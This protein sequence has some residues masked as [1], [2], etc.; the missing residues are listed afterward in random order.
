MALRFGHIG[1]GDEDDDP[2]V[3]Q[4]AG[5]QFEQIMHGHDLVEGHEEDEQGDE[6]EAIE[7]AVD[8]RLGRENATQQG[9]VCGQTANHCVAKV[10]GEEVE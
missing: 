7:E 1:Q 6:G 9:P 3:V 8:G 4:S 2:D 5:G 10:G